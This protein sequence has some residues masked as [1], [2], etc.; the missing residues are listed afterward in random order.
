MHGVHDIEVGKIAAP[1]EAG[2]YPAAPADPE[3]DTLREIL[4]SHYRRRIAEL[5]T[6]IDRLDRRIASKDELVA[7]ISPI[8]GDAIRDRIRENRQEMIDALYPIIGQLVLRAVSVAIR[9]LARSVDA[10][11]HSTF[12]LRALWERVRAR[13][14]GIAPAELALRDALPFRVNQL[15]LVHSGTGLLLRHISADR[16]PDANS[17]LFSG[18]LTAIRDFVAD[19]FGAL[20][21]D[22]LDEIEYGQYRIIIE[23]ARFCYAA[24]VIEGVEPAGFRSRLREC[25]FEIEADGLDG[26]RSY[27]GAPIVLPGADAV[28]RSLL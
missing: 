24:A 9:D 5:Q 3:L 4:F 21:G 13:L 23:A 2:R 18:M 22:Q 25:L 14:G 17:D 19:T 1:E 6:E 12:S 7:T 15:F 8:L 27:D 11:M 20:P 10:R 26:L 16:E 28:L